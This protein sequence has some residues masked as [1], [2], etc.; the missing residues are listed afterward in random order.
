MEYAR[1]TF[2]FEVVQA[3]FRRN[4]YAGQAAGYIA[5]CTVYTDPAL[6]KASRGWTGG[7]FDLILV[8][9]LYGLTVQCTV[10]VVQYVVIVCFDLPWF[11]L[12]RFSG[13]SLG[14]MVT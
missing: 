9:V 6:T 5:Q 1:H 14:W 10:H 4:R 12:F 7:W 8:I 3:H 11:V 13:C 2:A